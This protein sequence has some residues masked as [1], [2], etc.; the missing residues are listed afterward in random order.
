[1]SV[2]LFRYHSVA[3]DLGMQCVEVRDVA[4]QPTVHRTN[5]MTKNDQDQ[6]VSITKAKQ[7]CRREGN[8]S[9]QEPLP[10]H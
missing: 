6:E 8:K 7:S 10:K 9:K 2:D 4:K 5:L 1:M 3:G